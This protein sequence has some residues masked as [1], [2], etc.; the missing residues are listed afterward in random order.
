MTSEFLL[1][2]QMTYCLPNHRYVPGLS[3]GGWLGSHARHSL[4]SMLSFQLSA[5][6]LLNFHSPWSARIHALLR[7]GSQPGCWCSSLFGFCLQGKGNY[8]FAFC[9]LLVSEF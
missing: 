9:Q 2:A 8:R 6:Y 7:E 1:L 3:P 4:C 5:D